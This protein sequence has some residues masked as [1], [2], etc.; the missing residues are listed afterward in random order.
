MDVVD[1]STIVVEMRG[2]D[3]FVNNLRRECPGLKR[4]DSFSYSVSGNQLCLSDSITVLETFNG[5][6]RRGFSCNLGYF[7][8]ITKEE[9]DFLKNSNSE[10][11]DRN[12]RSAVTTTSLPPADEDQADSDDTPS[13]PEEE[14]GKK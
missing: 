4:R 9:A 1:D 11:R 13:A 3:Y 8:P 6:P 7:A 2:G 14:Q 5:L 10:E 12:K